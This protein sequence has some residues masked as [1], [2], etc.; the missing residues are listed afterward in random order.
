MFN[1]LEK[2]ISFCS[3]HDEFYYLIGDIIEE[4]YISEW[5]ENQSLTW[6]GTYLALVNIEHMNAPY[7]MIDGYGHLR[8]IAPDDIRFMVYE[9]TNNIEY[10]DDEEYKTEL[11]DELTAL[12]GEDE[13]DKLLD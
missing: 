13:L 2:L 1:R 11:F 7:F 3:E 8:D 10:S 5:L 4:D 9:I 12:F 6:K